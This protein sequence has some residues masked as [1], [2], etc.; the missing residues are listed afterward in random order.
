MQGAVIYGIVVEDPRSA[1]L[2]RKVIRLSTIAAVLVIVGNVINT[3]S[4]INQ[5]QPKRNDYSGF[6]Q[7]G[8][9]LLVPACGY[10]GAKQRRRDLLKW[11]W[12]CNAC[13][14]VLSLFAVGFVCYFL[15]TI[16]TLQHGMIHCACTT[17]AFPLY[18]LKTNECVAVPE[19]TT[20]VINGGPPTCDN[21]TAA[22]N[23]VSVYLYGGIAIGIVTFLLSCASC[24]YGKELSENQTFITPILGAPFMGTATSHPYQ[25]A[26]QN[27]QQPPD[28][29]QQPAVAYQQP[30]VAYQPQ[31]TP[32]KY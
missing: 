17:P 25:P 1:V 10:Y 16:N 11:F 4:P 20:I 8:L 23:G 18:D 12:G 7:I 15:P 32:Q 9:G 14:A 28:A 19:G 29:Y 24:T 3:M 31:A 22:F 6:V 30:A 5:L 2:V 13:Q 27:Y 26:P 21:V